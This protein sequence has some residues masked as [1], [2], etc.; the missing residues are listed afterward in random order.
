MS[1]NTSQKGKRKAQPT[2]EDRRNLRKFYNNPDGFKGHKPSQADAITWAR[3]TLD[4]TINQS[5]VSKWTSDKFKHLDTAS[6]RAPKAA[7]EKKRR[8][9]RSYHSLELALFTWMRRMEV[10]YPITGAILQEKASQLFKKMPMYQSQKE[11]KWSNG[12]LYNFQKEYGINKSR[13]FGEAASAAAINCDEDIE[14]IQQKILEYELDDVWNC[15][16]TGKS[17]TQP[18]NLLLTLLG[19]FYKAVPDVSLTTRSLPGYKIKKERLTAM[20][21]CSATGKKMKIWFIGKSKTPRCFKNMNV[22]SM[23]LKYSNNKKA[24]MTTVV[25]IEYLNWFDKQM[26]LRGR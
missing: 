21:T 12:W 6:T 15:D 3:E 22:E 7:A 17:L 8:R 9:E 16:E 25:M 14:E 26:R 10:D 24:W 1:L 11:P 5:Q 23:N 13:R 18:I 4:I 19:L 2:D 20:H